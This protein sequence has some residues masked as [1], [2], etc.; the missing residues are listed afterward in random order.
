M[1]RKILAMVLILMMTVSLLSSTAVHAE[2]ADVILTITPSQEEAY[3]GD[4]ITYTVSMGAVTELCSIQMVLLL[5][6]GLEYVS[7]SGALVSGVAEAFRF[8]LLNWTESSQMFNGSAGLYAYTSTE[9]TELFQFECKVAEDAEPGELAVTL[10]EVELYDASAMNDSLGDEIPP[11]PYSI[12]EGKI[13]AKP[14]PVA[15]SGITITPETKE[16][17]EEGEMFTITSVIT[18]E[19]ADNTNVIYTSSDSSV[20]VVN[21]SGEVTVVANGQAMI[22]VTSEENPEITAQ[23]EVVVNIPHRH[24]MTEI[25]GKTSSCLEQGNG[26]YYYCA[27]CEAYFKDSEGTIETT[28][29]EEKLPL[30]SHT[31]GTANCHT[32]AA[33]TVCFAEYG[34]YDALNHAGG[35][36]VRDII[37]AT[38]DSGGYTG[39]TYCKGCGEMLAEGT[40]TDKLPHTHN[41]S[42]VEATAATHDD[43]GN[44][45][46]YQC[47]KCGKL[48]GDLEGVEEI[49]LTDTVI[50][51]LGH[52]MTEITAKASSCT[53]QGNNLYYYCN[54][55]ETYFKDAAGTVE[56]TSDAEKLPLA[57]HTGG[58]ATCHTKAVC[59]VCHT[60]YGEY[61]AANHDGGVEV[62]NVVAATEEAGGYTGDTY[63]LGCYELIAEGTATA[64]LAHTHNM[65]KVDAVAAT[66]EEAGNIEYYTCTKCGNLFRDEAGTEV[67][68]LA[69]TI[70]DAVGHTYGEE[71]QSDAENHW[72]ECTCGSKTEVSVHTGGTAT[73]HTKAVCTVC[74]TEYGEYDATNHDGE[75]EV[76]NAVLA[77]EEAGGY[78]GDTYC[79]G[80]GQMIAEG[81]ATAPLAHT[82]A[83]ELVAT[84]APTHEEAGNIAYYT[85][86]KCGNLFADEAGEQVITLADTIL[87][88][89]G[90]IYQ[91]QCDENN[92]WEAC[93]CGSQKEASAHTYG[94]WTEVQ[95]PTAEQC[96]IKERTCTVCGYQ[97]T[98]EIAP[99]LEEE[100]GSSTGDNALLLWE[101]LFA[102]SGIGAISM[103]GSMKKKKQVK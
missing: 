95:A 92:H 84:V 27:G 81:T 17:T 11:L 91:Y 30:A 20:A 79:L 51:A 58:T 32:K 97:E 3:P 59:T 94:E 37:S 78:T 38:E 41:M 70:L 40:A 74:H 44:I 83:M 57:V 19:N 36:E 34:D 60:E 62:R 2:L 13:T 45:E 67:I 10:Q 12:V 76:R 49:S 18:P 82:H 103:F 86:T 33:C 50:A 93:D 46:Y 99:S 68:T 42:L 24:T 35:T 64:P 87:S 6:E 39:D 89:E 75:V 25:S 65:V 29:E 9:E 56:T 69:D 101:L 80:C 48:F 100:D 1:R 23:C 102:I 98:A 43:A 53:E 63:C 72:K 55:C 16:L 96:G 73:C 77:T 61:D 71:Y 47:S 90:H 28:P 88:A 52:T 85:C 4:V 66:H 26:Q 14:A 7:G 15:V 5:P 8:D 21:E 31:G 22:T 54:G